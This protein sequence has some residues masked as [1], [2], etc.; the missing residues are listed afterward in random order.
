VLM[1][2]HKNVIFQDNGTGY[3]DQKEKDY[4]TGLMKSRMVWHTLVN[5][6]LKDLNKTAYRCCHC[7]LGAACSSEYVKSL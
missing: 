4:A 7:T 3:C 6:G 5:F 1:E 2:V